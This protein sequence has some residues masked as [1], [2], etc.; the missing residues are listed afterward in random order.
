MYVLGS[1]KGQEAFEIYLYV[2]FVQMIHLVLKYESCT[3]IYYITLS[4]C[5]NVESQI[6][7]STLWHKKRQIKRRTL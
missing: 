6:R 3:L 1:F 4:S 2:V 7:E 5:V